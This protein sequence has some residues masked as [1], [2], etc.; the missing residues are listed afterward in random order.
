M[1]AAVCQVQFIN[2]FFFFYCKGISSNFWVAIFLLFIALFAKGF[3]AYGSAVNPIDIA[4]KH[5]G[6]V[7]G[8]SYFTAATAGL[9]LN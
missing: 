8:I 9:R 6:S 7:S 5:S 2:S 4:P 3:H 1:P